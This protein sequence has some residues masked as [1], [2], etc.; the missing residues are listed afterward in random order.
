MKENEKTSRHKVTMLA[1][2]SPWPFTII[3][4]ISLI[5]EGEDSISHSPPNCR[6]VTMYT[7]KNKYWAKSRFMY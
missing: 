2:L 3:N 5:V 4:I 1:N 7:G 6:L